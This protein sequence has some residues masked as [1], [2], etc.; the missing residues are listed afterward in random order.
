MLLDLTTKSLMILLNAVPRWMRPL[1]YGGPSCR[2][3][4]GRPARD[5]RIRLY[6]PSFS[7]RS[8]IFGSV[9]GRLAFIEKA[10]FGRLTVCFKSTFGES[11]GGVT[12]MVAIAA[13]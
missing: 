4:V 2:T 3:Y 12:S 5:S 13:S 9:V 8:S 1:A 6:R 10:V 7:H 11:I